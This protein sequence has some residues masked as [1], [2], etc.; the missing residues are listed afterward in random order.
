VYA[1]QVAN[2]IPIEEYGRLRKYIGK[3][4]SARGPWWRK[5]GDN[6]YV[7]VKGRWRQRP[8]AY[9][10]PE[11]KARD[12]SGKN[13]LICKPF[14][15]FGD[16]A[17]DIPPDLHQVIKKGPGHKRVREAVLLQRFVDWL[18]TMPVGCH[19]TPATILHTQRQRI[20]CRRSVCGPKKLVAKIPGRY[21][22][23][24]L[25]WGTPVGKEAW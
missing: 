10:G 3:R 24:E 6:I 11:A 15:Y 7:K 21:C 14:W 2:V 12:I 1:A 18:Q 4:P 23:K 13:V 25:D 5:C 9:H 20:G 8:N 22:G 17:V 19:G 16:A